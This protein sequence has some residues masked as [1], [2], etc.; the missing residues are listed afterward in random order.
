MGDLGVERVCCLLHNLIPGGSGWQWVR[1]LGRH[2]EQGGEA[3]IF[4]PAGLLAEPAR[5]AGI[6]VVDVSWSETGETAERP[7]RSALER[8]DA[9][10]VHWDHEVMNR[11]APAAEACG[12]VALVVHQAPQAMQWL[13]PEVVEEGRRAIEAALADPRGVVLVRGAAHRRRFAAAFGLPGPELQV[14]P[15]SIPVEA[16]PFAPQLGEPRQVLSLTRLSPEKAPVI[17]LAVNLV[18]HRLAFGRPC[19]LSLAGAGSWRAEAIELCERSLPAGCWRVEDAPEHPLERLAASD[20][21]V[22]QGVTTLEAAAL[23]RRVVVARKAG[24]EGAAG[25]ALTAAGYDEAGRD[26]FGEP[27]LTADPRQ[28]W[29]NALAVGEAELRDLRGLIEAHNSLPAAARALGAALATI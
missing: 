9:A 15:A 4:A 29:S 23:G 5:A 12:R 1:L 14:L 22:A 16:I 3:T 6:D 10:I 24:E 2:V 7:L 21:V 17:R 20:L 26:P 13:G 27:P 19:M 11:F 28:L 8:A 18:R 25:A